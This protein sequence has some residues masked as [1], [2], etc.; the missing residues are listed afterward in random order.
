MLPSLWG[1]DN[2]L[3][4]SSLLN[5]IYIYICILSAFM[6]LISPLLICPAQYTRPLHE[7]K[8]TQLKMTELRP[9]LRWPDPSFTA[10]CQNY[11]STPFT[12]ISLSD[13]E[14]E[15]L[16]KQIGNAP[17]LFSVIYYPYMAAFHWPS[18][19]GV[20]TRALWLTPMPSTMTND[21]IEHWEDELAFIMPA[22]T[23]C[24]W[25]I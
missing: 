23:K 22:E 14:R 7:L 18:Q 11:V 2:P 3:A 20:L 21:A 9:N 15:T 16:N 13:L 25:A 8:V 6:T 10:A 19:R 17:M 4:I 5:R 24:F 1:H 12:K